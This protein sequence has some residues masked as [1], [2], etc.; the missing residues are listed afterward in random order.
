MRFFEQHYQ[1]EFLM[2][3]IY[4]KLSPEELHEFM[5]SAAY[6]KLVFSKSPKRK[7]KNDSL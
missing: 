7:P 6:K 4:G 2:K 3:W 1:N 5:T